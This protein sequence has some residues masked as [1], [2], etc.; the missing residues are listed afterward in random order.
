MD[1]ER[2]LYESVKRQL[3]KQDWADMNAY[4]SAKTE[5]VEQITARALSESDGI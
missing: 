4:A 2:L 3:A 1:G 5:V